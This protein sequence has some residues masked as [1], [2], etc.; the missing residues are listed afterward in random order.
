MSKVKGV[1]LSADSVAYTSSVSKGTNYATPV[2]KGTNKV[3][4]REA[5]AKAFCSANCLRRSA[6][7]EALSRALPPKP[8]SAKPASASRA[9]RK[10]VILKSPKQTSTRS[11]RVSVLDRL[12]A[13]N[14]DL[15]EFLTNKRKLELLHTS[16]SCCKQVG[17]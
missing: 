7:I 9:I 13:V 12:S 2:P 8:S 16:P 3:S 15:R 6:K 5:G 11:S 10:K 14:P 4:S 17:C 1:S